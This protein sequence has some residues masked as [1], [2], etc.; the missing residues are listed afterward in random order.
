M[1]EMKHVQVEFASHGFTYIIKDTSIGG[2]HSI[3]SPSNNVRISRPFAITILTDHLSA[4][5]CT[6]LYRTETL[7]LHVDSSNSIHTLR[8][9]AY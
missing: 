4:Q 8:S 2:I 5:A 9:I 1:T 7:D 6:K 3:Q